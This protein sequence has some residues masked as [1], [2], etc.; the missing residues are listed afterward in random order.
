MEKYYVY[1][2]EDEQGKKYKGMTN[3]LSRRLQEH[4][5]GKTFTTRKM[6]DLK[7]VYFEEY[8]TRQEARAREVYFKTAAGR[9]F[10]K[11]KRL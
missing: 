5:A 11:N 3:N 8:T 9:R 7:L 1:V 4:K 6:S 2:L 10:L